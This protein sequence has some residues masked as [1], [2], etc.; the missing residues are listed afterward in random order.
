[1]IRLKRRSACSR[2]VPVSCGGVP[3]AAGSAAGSGIWLIGIR[4]SFSAVEL[5]PPRG[6]NSTTAMRTTSAAPAAYQIGAVTPP[7]ISRTAVPQLVQKFAPLASGALHDLHFAP[8]SGVPHS[9]QKAPFESVP[10]FGH[11][12]R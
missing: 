10:Q 6:H 3:A 9:E 4:P 11:F 1:M 8:L 2:G 5:S 7:E 12:I